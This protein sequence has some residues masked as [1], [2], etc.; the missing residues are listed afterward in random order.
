MQISSA[1]TEP[2][3]PAQGLRNGVLQWSCL[4]ALPSL[5]ELLLQLLSQHAA[6]EVNTV[7]SSHCFGK[8]CR[9]LLLPGVVL[10]HVWQLQA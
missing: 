4:E 1:S 7:A 3:L 9:K 8:L 6:K 10:E 5:M 2:C